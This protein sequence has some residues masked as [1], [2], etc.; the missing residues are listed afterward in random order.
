MGIGVVVVTF[1]FDPKGRGSIP[2]SP[3][4]IYGVVVQWLERATYNRLIQVQL[5]FTP[6][7]VKLVI[8]DLLK[9][10]CR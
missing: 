3:A 6:P 1:G 9:S 10:R 7:V 8:S 5:L 4:N 2:L